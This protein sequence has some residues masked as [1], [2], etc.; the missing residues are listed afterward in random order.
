MT[1]PVSRLLA[2]LGAAAFCMTLTAQHVTDEVHVTV[3]DDVRTVV[4]DS[5]ADGRALPLPADS[6]LTDGNRRM[7]LPLQP[8]G[9]RM[10]F[11][12]SPL[13]GMGWWPLHEGLN[14]QVELSLSTG[15]GH[16][17]LRG[18]GFGQSTALA[19]AMPLNERFSVA[20]GLYAMHMDWDGIS[21]TQGGVAAALCYRLTDRVNLYAYGSKAFT[22]DTGLLRYPLYHAATLYAPWPYVIPR[23]RIGAM[24]EFKIGEAATIAVSVEHH[25]Y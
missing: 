3:A 19:Y 16:H 14:A 5:T 6:C 21:R 12:L 4:A 8:A 17:R 23:E 15:F 13:M 1:M 25:K 10:T 9:P 18:V 11:P 20:A 24:A 7:G 22:P 2:T